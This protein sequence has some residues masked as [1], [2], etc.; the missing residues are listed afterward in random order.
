MKRR[1]FNRKKTMTF[2]KK[3]KN[4]ELEDKI[5]KL[6]REVYGDKE[7]S[8]SGD[9]MG[10]W[11][12]DF[13]DMV[14]GSWSISLKQRVDSLQTALVK[15]EKLSHLILEHL[16]LEYVKITEENGRETIKE[17]L[18]PIAKKKLEAKKKVES[19]N[20]DCCDYVD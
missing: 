9:W 5:A 8:K 15:Q 12:M 3:N 2:F 16:K 14:N 11:T 18:R 1:L 13:A 19:Y 4:N 6:E 10:I 7:K 17:I 20:C